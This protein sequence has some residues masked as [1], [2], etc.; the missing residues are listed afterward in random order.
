MERIWSILELKIEEPGHQARRVDSGV[1]CIV[2]TSVVVGL[3][4]VFLVESSLEFS[5]ERFLVTCAGETL[6]N[7]WNIPWV[8]LDKWMAHP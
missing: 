7:E 3:R 1:S 5:A 2:T 4:V 8:N 6:I